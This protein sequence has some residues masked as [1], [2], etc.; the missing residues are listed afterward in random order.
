MHGCA[1]AADPVWKK[2]F[3]L[4]KFYEFDQT[5]EN[6]YMSVLERKAIRQRLYKNYDET[7]PEDFKLFS[8]KFICQ[9]Y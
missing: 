1:P 9:L 8:T 3:W 6:K 5:F 2:A 4:H 7:E